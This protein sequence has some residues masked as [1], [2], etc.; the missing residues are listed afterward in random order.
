MD[1]A[2]LERLSIQKEVEENE[3]KENKVTEN[4]GHFL[5]ETR[6]TGNIKLSTI[7]KLLKVMGG[8]PMHILA[9][10]LPFGNSLLENIINYLFL[11]YASKLTHSTKRDGIELIAA[12]SVS[13]SLIGFVRA[14]VIYFSG[15]YASKR[16]HASMSFGLLYSKIEE[17]IERV[18][19]G[20]ILNRFS[21]D[22]EVIDTSLT[23]AFSM[24]YI[25]FAFSITSMI[26]IAVSA[27]SYYL[28][29]PSAV[30]FVISFNVRQGYMNAKREI[31]RMK[32]ITKSPITSLL[33]QSLHGMIE[34]RAL[35]KLNFVMKE[36]DYLVDENNK[37]SITILGLDSW[38]Q[39]NLLNYSLLLVILPSYSYVFWVLFRSPES[40][41][42]EMIMIF[43]LNSTLLA[44]DI[45]KLLQ[46]LNGLESNIISVERCIEIERLKSEEGY[47][48]LKEEIKFSKGSRAQQRKVISK[49]G[50]LELI[51][52]HGAISMINVE[53]KYAS[54]ERNV[55]E[56]IN[57][58]IK[59]GEKIG[60][61]G[62][63]GAGKSSFIKLFWRVLPFNGTISFDDFDISKLGLKELR[64]QTLIIS[65]E[66]ALFNG[67]LRENIDPNLE[68]GISSHTE[69]ESKILHIL[70][71]IGFDP[72]KL[73][74]GLDF[75]I[76][77]NGDNLS[78]GE[79][80]IIAFMRAAITDKK[81]VVMDEA[82][83]S[84]DLKTEESIQIITKEHLSD[85]TLIIIA[86]RIQT[87]LDCDRVMVLDNGHIAEF[88]SISELLKIENGKFKALYNK[89]NSGL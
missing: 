33:A 74:N 12:L 39:T 70:K 40:I 65:Q 41:S 73:E 10:L 86:H 51:V 78:L 21:E 83:A 11:L 89:F 24:L 57:A 59:A 9:S 46:T 52:R 54:Q 22:V 35:R 55:L 31:L 80:Q 82:T 48:N 56:G 6:T 69:T 60:I 8:I 1:R 58:E 37:N 20:R 34:I 75:T 2:S 16:I 67:T 43:I 32:R 66:A 87:V 28:F 30:F 76:E 50:N 84:I 63:T 62:R 15:Y 64:R 18:P 25:F 23:V 36:L 27:G 4:D 29:I 85:K 17:F 14:L 3:V 5:E 53:A 42:V 61:V 49:E 19:I 72:K 13:L 45:G 81:I 26:I 68:Y 47:M 38:F 88:D 77:G 79:K 7:I 71:S 44:D